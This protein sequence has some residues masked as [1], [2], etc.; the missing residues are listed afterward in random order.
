MGDI[1][2]TS[3]VRSAFFMSSLST[4]RFMPAPA[5]EHCVRRGSCSISRVSSLMASGVVAAS[6]FVRNSRSLLQNAAS[7]TYSLSCGCCMHLCTGSSPMKNLRRPP[8]GSTVCASLASAIALILLAQLH[9]VARCAACGRDGEQRSRS[10]KPL[11]QGLPELHDGSK[12]L[13]LREL[14]PYW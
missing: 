12:D 13:L 5:M 14:G 4:V 7:V 2:S 6:H 3:P 8:A 9:W 1:F 10:D 11:P